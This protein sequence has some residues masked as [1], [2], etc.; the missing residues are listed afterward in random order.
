MKRITKIVLSMALIAMMVAGNF[1]ISHAETR[2][3]ALSP[4]GDHY[5]V[6]H[7]RQGAGYSQ[8]LS[9]HNHYMGVGPNGELQYETCQRTQYFE[10]CYYKCV[11][12]HAVNTQEP[13]H[14]HSYIRHSATNSN[15]YVN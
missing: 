1:L 9:S 14:T 15:E 3:C 5:F 13:A 10:Y 6:D 11:Y 8:T 12:C 4:T 7:E 2:G